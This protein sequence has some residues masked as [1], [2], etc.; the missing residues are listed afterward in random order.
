MRRLSAIEEAERQKRL[1]VS[2][3]QELHRSGRLAL[4][5]LLTQETELLQ[6]SLQAASLRFMAAEADL[7]F[8][9]AAGTL[10]IETALAITGDHTP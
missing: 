2:A 3:Q 5:E 7:D 9:R 8:H 1:F 6:L 10:T 4:S